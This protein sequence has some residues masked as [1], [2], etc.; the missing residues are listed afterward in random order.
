M[1]EDSQERREGSFAWVSGASVQQRLQL[2]RGWGVSS[3][4]DGSSLEGGSES[5]VEWAPGRMEAGGGV[6]GEHG[7][8]FGEC[9]G[10]QSRWDASPEFRCLCGV[11]GARGPFLC[12][13]SALLGMLSKCSRPRE[14]FS[15]PLVE[16][17][18]QFC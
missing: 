9:A 8:F 3:N 2:G 13:S 18:T 5:Q 10:G 4:L 12:I 7:L 17:K 16:K 11:Q 15:P 1:R 6:E 14:F